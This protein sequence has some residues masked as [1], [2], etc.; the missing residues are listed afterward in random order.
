MDSN[1]LH[2]KNMMCQR[3]IRSVEKIMEKL[4]IETEKIILDQAITKTP[5]ERIN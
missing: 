5:K 3:C 4:D 1:V 2:F